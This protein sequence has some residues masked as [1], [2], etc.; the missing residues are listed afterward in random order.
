MDGA[1]GLKTVISVVYQEH[2]KSLSQRPVLT[3]IR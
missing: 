2:L 1:S 3:Y